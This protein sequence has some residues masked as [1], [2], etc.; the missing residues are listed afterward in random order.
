MRHAPRGEVTACVHDRRWRKIAD[1]PWHDRAVLWRVQAR[2]FRCCRCSGRIF[3]EPLPASTGTAV[4][5][6]DRLARAQTSMGLVLGG[7]AGARLSG[8][9]FMPVSDD[10]VLRRLGFWRLVVRP[11][12]PGHDRAAQASFSA[13]S[14]PSYTQHCRTTTTASR[15]SCGSRTR[16]VSVSRAR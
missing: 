11:H 12:H 6:S 3:T 14:P 8:R 16:P 4:R 13:T 2:R 15:W 10:T 5:R 7:E 9:L 1:L